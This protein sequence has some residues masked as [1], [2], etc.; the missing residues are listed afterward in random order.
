MKYAPATK[1]N[2]F[3]FVGKHFSYAST[4]ANVVPEYCFL[5]WANRERLIRNM[6]SLFTFT[7]SSGI[8][9]W[10]RY[11]RIDWFPECNDCPSYF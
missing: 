7:V 9:G 4:E 6:C 11:P 8:R 10:F 3:E 1:I 2:S 5:G